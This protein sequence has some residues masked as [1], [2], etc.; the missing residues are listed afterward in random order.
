LA[1]PPATA[2]P[3]PRHTAASARSWRSCC[4]SCVSRQVGDVARAVALAWQVMATYTLRSPWWDSGQRMLR[5]REKSLENALSQGAPPA[6]ARAELA[7][8]PHR[9]S[10]TIKDWIAQGILPREGSLLEC[11]L[12]AMNHFAEVKAG[13]RGT[14][15]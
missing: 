12:S 4:L 10:T 2:R 14:W 8:G 6:M 7:I 5:A 11:A 3:R 1:S 9:S 13:R 15:A